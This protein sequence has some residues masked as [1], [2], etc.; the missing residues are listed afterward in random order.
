MNRY[1]TKIGRRQFLVAGGTAMALLRRGKADPRPL[2]EEIPPEASGIR[3]VHDNAA[4]PDHY[5]PETMGPGC[6]FVDYD[7]DGW[8][9]IFLVNSGPCDFYKPGKPIRNAL[10]K[11]N[12]DGTFT[13]VT[14]KAGVAGGTLGTFGMGVAVGDYDNDGF[15]DLFV[16][17][18]GRPILYRNNGNGSFSDVT[19]KAGLGGKVFE[20]HWTTSAVW[21]DFDNDGRLDLFVCSFV[22]YGTTSHF[23]CG[24]NKLGR[25]FYCIP[26][27]FRPTASLLFHNNGDGTFT[28]VSRGTDIEKALGKG[29]GVVATDIN[30][31]GLM[32][33]F[34]ANDT[35]QN[36]LFVNRGADAKG[37]TRWEEI[38]LASEVGFSQDGKARSGMGVDAADFDGD[39]WQDLFVANVDQEMFSLYRNNHNE[40]FRDVAFKN[41]VAQAT[42]LLSGWGLKFFDYDNDGLLDLFLANGHPDDMIDNYSQQVRYREPLLLFHQ[43]GGQLHNVSADAGLVF[44]RSFAARGLAIGDFNNDGRVDVLIGN[45]GGAPLLL[46]NNGGQENHWLGVKLQGTKCNR[47]AI[48]AR[49]TWS[50]GG[51]ERSRLKNGGGS[52]L[53]S[54]DPRDVLGVG[55]AGKIDWLEIQWPGPGRGRERLTDLPIDR[56]ITIV[57]GKGVVS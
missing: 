30:N 46:R 14:E 45:N 43:E 21:F 8:M 32:D 40:T 5:L 24:D 31:D 22:D 41:G 11:N 15:P 39:G 56:Y 26:R 47:D 37:K 29:L 25:H 53:S 13:D 57:E 50:A 6:A 4:S 33:L 38:A 1:S 42:R 7:N 12:R 48:G 28:E 9:D 19:E 3:W 49:L 51:I 52:Y 10:Y 54:H 36:F 17:A 35:V 34:V 2:F 18:Y 23:S 44:S 16:T 27:V 55:S 20:N